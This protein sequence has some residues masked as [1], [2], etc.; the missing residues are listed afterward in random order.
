[1]TDLFG[2]EE[3]RQTAREKL[4]E[5]AV[6]LR[7]FALD[8]EVDLLAAIQ[9]IT[10]VSP[11]RRMAT[12]GGHVMS[13]AMTNCGQAGWVTDRTGYHYDATDPETGKPWHPMPESFMALAVF[14]ATEAGYCRFRPDTCLINRYEPGAKLSLHQDRNE[15]EFAHPIVSVSLGLPATF[16]FG[17]LRRADPI[18]KYALRH[19]DVAVW[20]G[21]S[22]LCHHGVLAL[23]E[24]AHPKLGRMRLNLT[25]RG[26][27]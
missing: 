10:T 12:P 26:A 27:L 4:A 15:R 25:F 16:Q 24:G 3:P 19:G 22:R 14:A 8:C 20:G 2:A 17:G 23:K 11:F 13:V 18:R 21:P 9:A 7:G 5:G 1:M 6:L